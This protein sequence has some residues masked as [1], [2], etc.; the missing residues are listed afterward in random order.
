MYLFEPTETVAVVC[1]TIALTVL[2][3][4][5]F[6]LYLRCVLESS[7][8][9]IHAQYICRQSAVA[10]QRTPSSPGGFTAMEYLVRRRF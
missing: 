6:G 7:H 4:E 2:V 5:P 10:G 8:P 3:L 9:F 1:L